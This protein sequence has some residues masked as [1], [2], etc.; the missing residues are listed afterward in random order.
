[1]TGNDRS[2]ARNAGVALARAL[3]DELSGAGVTFAC[4]APGSRSTPLALALAAHP[5]IALHV[6]LDERSAA[7]VA[8]GAASFARRPALV[9]TTSGTAAANVFPAVQEA[10]HGRV[11]LIVLTADRPPELRDTGANQT[12]D[13]IKLFG[14]AVR[15]FVEV[16]TAQGVPDEER[17][18]RSLAGRAAAVATGSP[19]G[20]VHLNVAFREPL[21]GAPESEPPEEA[22]PG[23][24]TTFTP[25]TPA[26]GAEDVDGLLRSLSGVQRGAVLAGPGP[27]RDAGA[28]RVAEALGWPLLADPLSNQR[29]GPNAISTYDA[30]LRNE[31]FASH[32]RPEVVLRVGGLGISKN[33]I[34]WSGSADRHLLVDPDGWP[35][36][37]ERSLDRVYACDP[38]SLFAELADR[39]SPASQSVWLEEWL[40]ADAAARSAIDG[41]LDARPLTEPRL[42]RDLVAAVPTGANVF[43]G[44]SMPF[45]HIEW[46]ARPRGD[47]LFLG[48]R[49]ANGIDGSVATPLGVAL[50]S[51][52][53]TFA[54]I[55]DLSLLHDQNAL[56][57]RPPELDLTLVIPNNDGGG[58]FSF[59]PQAQAAPH[60]ER[61]FGTPHGRDLA[62]L[63]R[64]HGCDHLRTD[65]PAVLE[66][67][68]RDTARGTQ[69]IEVPADRSATVELHR[70]IH[71]AVSGALG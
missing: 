69:V 13:Q 68:L 54:L 21:L 58:I 61:L 56:L 8:L 16:G 49:G 22:P 25:G 15:W 5:K 46:F 35:L 71:A 6:T 43:V 4:L 41:V 65:D 2:G 48:N 45:R 60:F 32:H 62:A 29:R 63:A 53:P 33:L 51:A 38:R 37:P 66:R 57:M 12:I 30:L 14:D 55:G 3:V 1:M 17:Y 50:D 40:R 7:F 24:R 31:A 19:A 28:D 23:G 42:A 26:L 11:P 10:H 47:V 9:L 52:A 18:W 59:L 34:R 20:P 36:D 67:A 39:A 64:F 27:V 70:E 44:A